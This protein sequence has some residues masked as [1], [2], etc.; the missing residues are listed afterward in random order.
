VLRLPGTRNYKAKYG[1]DFPTVQ[2]LKADFEQLYSF[3]QL[4]TLVPPVPAPKVKA[5]HQ[6]GARI[7]AADTDAPTDLG[8]IAEISAL[9]QRLKPERADNYNTWLNVGMICKDELGAAGLYLWKAWA[10]Q[11]GAYEPGCC[12]QK[13]PTFNSI[14]GGEPV[15]I[16][17]LRYWA[18]EDDPPIQAAPDDPQTVAE[19][20]RQ[21]DTLY[22]QV[23]KLEQWREWSMAVAALPT[24]KLSPAAKVVAFTLW[25]EMQ[26]REERGLTEPASIWIEGKAPSA[27]L[28]AGTYGK[29]LA[30]VAQAGALVR[31]EARDPV[32]GHSKALIAPAAWKDPT[33]WAPPEA[34]NHGG[35]RPNA[36]R[37]ALPLCDSPTCSPETPV[38]EAAVMTVEYTSACGKHLGTHE[39]S[40]RERTWQP[41][42]D[43]Q[44]TASPWKRAEPTPNNQPDCC[45]PEQTNKQHAA[46]ET[47]MASPATQVACWPA[48]A[49]SPPPE[50]D[51]YRPINAAYQRRRIVEVGA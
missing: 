7:A 13:W 5:T 37:P 33:S 39:R 19:L 38:T 10:Q 32:T 27:G 43:G 25:P 4:A 11:S 3:E 50:G 47:P 28:S 17:S 12:E 30:E 48:A 20:C 1:P 35:Q 16:G 21:I 2:F 34:R 40:R 42:Q 46:L 14:V 45:P 23:E 15:T 8:K 6:N 41:D 49:T 51:P 26:S 29:R 22:T 9:L 18:R 36:G 24:E 31:E 44:W